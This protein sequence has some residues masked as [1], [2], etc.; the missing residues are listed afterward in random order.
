MKSYINYIHIIYICIELIPKLYSN[1]SS[2]KVE[3]NV[4]FICD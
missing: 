3:P 1:G 4:K 2:D